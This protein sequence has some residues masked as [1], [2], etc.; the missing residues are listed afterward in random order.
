M[1][2]NFWASDADGRVGREAAKEYEIVTRRQQHGRRSA[3]KR[4]VA[5]ISLGLLM[6]APAGPVAAASTPTDA[7]SQAPVYEVDSG[8]W[9]A[10]R[11]SSGSWSSPRP[12]RSGSW[13]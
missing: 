12:A 1:T 4:V 3:L 6:L 2:P 8:S 11:P 9:S 5:G 13:S 7:A 10:P